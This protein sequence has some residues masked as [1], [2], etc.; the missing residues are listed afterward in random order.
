[1]TDK[2]DYVNFRFHVNA[3]GQVPSPG[4]DMRDNVDS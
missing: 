3:V 2:I 4:R 1:M